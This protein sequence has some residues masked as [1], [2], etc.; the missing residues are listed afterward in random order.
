MKRR[1]QPLALF[2]VVVILLSGFAVLSPTRGARA[3]TRSP[4]ID[5]PKQTRSPRPDA[6]EQDASAQPQAQ[7]QGLSD[8][9]R[10]QIESL[11]REKESRNKAQAK[12]DSQLIYA[13]KQQRGEAITDAVETLEVDV[14]VDERGYTLV[15]IRA[16]VTAQVLSTIRQVGGKVIS[17]FPRDEAIRASLP[18]SSI[19]TVAGLAEV[20]FIRPAEV[21]YTEKVDA[22]GKRAVSDVVVNP[23]GAPRATAPPAEGAVNPTLLRG[24]RPGFAERAANT[25]AR[26]EA[27]LAARV[28]PVREDESQPDIGAA[29]AES[30]TTERTREARN[31]YGLN[32]KGIKIGI[33][34]D[35]FNFRNEYSKD[36]ATGDLPGP[37]NPYGYTTPVTVVQESSSTDEGRAM[38]QIIHD[39]VP[40]AQLFFATAN[41]GQANFA[42]NIRILRNTH[43]CDII[44]DD[45]GYFLES[46]LHKS[47]IVSRAVDD[48]VAAGAMYF[49]SAGNAGNFNDG[50]SGIW[51]GDFRDAGVGNTGGITAVVAGGTWH[52][53]DPGAAVATQNPVNRTTTENRAANLFWS[54]PLGGSCNDYDLYLISGTLDSGGAGQV[55]AASTTLQTCT[56]DPAEQVTVPGSASGAP[57]GRRLAIFKKATA[58]TRFLHLTTNRS[59]FDPVN[60]AAIPA[61]ETAGQANGHDATGD[62]YATAATPAQSPGPFPGV[63]TGAN[64]VETFSSDGPRRIFYKYDNTP[65][66]A[67]LTSTGGVVLQKPEITAA[68]RVSTTVPG[69]QPFSGTSAAA[70]TAAAIAALIKASSTSLTPTQ[71]LNSMT[72][73]AIDIEAPGVDRDS[74]VGIVMAYQALQSLS[75]P[76]GATVEAG[77][78][79]VTPANDCDSA[80]NPGEQGSITV[81]LNNVGGAT[82]TAVSATLTSSTAG[83][84]IT[85]GASAY[86]DIPNGG[87]ASNSTPFTFQLSN[88]LSC[89]Q[90]I[91]FSLRV[92][93]TGG[94]AS[95]INFPFTVQLAGTP[96][97][98][99]STFAYSGAPVTIP[100]NNS[101]GVN[102]P[103]TVSGFTGAVSDLN[104]KFGGTSCNATEGSTTNGVNHPFVGDV[105]F[106]LTSPSGKTVTIISQ[107]GGA[108]NSGNNFC[109]TV[110][111]DDTANG[112][113]QSVT[114]AQNPYTGTFKPANPLSAFDGENPNGTWLLNASDVG[115]TDV[116]NV[117]AFSLDITAFS[118]PASPTSTISG[119]IT[120]ANG[121]GID[122]VTVNLSG[123]ETQTTATNS[124]GDYSFSLTTCGLSYT[125]TPSKLGWAFTP[126]S[127][128][129]YGQTN[130]TNVNF[131]GTNAVTSPGQL[132]I[133]EFRL[134]G[135][136]GASD[137][138]IELYN[139]T[140]ANLVVNAADGSGGYALVASD[141]TTRHTIPSGTSIPARGHYLVTNSAGYSLSGYAA[142]DASFTVD[143]PDN[144]GVALFKTADGGGFTEAN[145]LDAAG[146]TS[147]PAL[148]REGAGLAP[149]DPTLNINHAFV[150]DLCGKDG[151]VTTFGPCPSGGLPTDSDD[152]AA[153]FFF[154]DTQGTQTGTVRR[155]GAPG[156]ESMASPVQRNSSF[157]GLSLDST[158]ASSSSPNRE[159]TIAQDTPNNSTFG[160]LSIRRRIVNNTGANV[161]RLRFRVID[162]STYEAPTGTADLRARTSS[163]VTVSDINDTA[164]CAAYGLTPPC[165]VTVQGTTLETPPTQTSGGGFNST[166]SV[167]VPGGSLANGASISV[168]FLLGIMQTGRFKFYVNI[169]ALTDVPPPPAAASAAQPSNKLR[170]LITES[171]SPTT[172]TL[173]APLQ[174]QPR[175]A[176]QAVP[177]RQ[178]QP[179]QQAPGRWLYLPHIIRTAPVEKSEPAAPEA[180][181]EP[182]APAAEPEPEQRPVSKKKKKRASSAK[183]AKDESGQDSPEEEGGKEGRDASEDS[184]ADPPA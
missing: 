66:T 27:A 22:D 31:F 92:T 41:G 36:I 67:D 95:P 111:D 48:V 127:R 7:E 112:S 181:P 123:S 160:T 69:F 164:T 38:A 29:T 65:Y 21:P 12:I 108:S 78:V 88:S 79:T 43:N 107:A 60:G 4:K 24:L 136:G 182:A 2:L 72:S 59:R 178:N 44:V 118:C 121:N 168:Q 133:T 106:K 61:W 49:A 134:R 115:A 125:V 56:Q 120:D 171:Q 90:T 139:N 34:S 14:K 151:S 9:T 94:Q 47:A 114:A 30:D 74:G 58:A 71:V 158:K 117:T 70:P 91:N 15:D 93:F 128:T 82:A 89:G 55:V 51:E 132:I 163:N 57:G 166:L 83:V 37:G 142:G 126:P 170:R 183:K 54:D 157:P 64:Q 18:L 148:Y 159:R 154:V 176:Q 84:T 40:G 5:A 138:F 156:P 145:R 105:I 13:A 149:I 62:G 146:F 162:I 42:N 103:V 33:L 75:T 122:A 68:D 6:P 3:Q 17:S 25:R 129:F 131:V 1:S 76:P 124:N 109:N 174:S 173:E 77:A 32:G 172:G 110:L 63:H 104:F 10:A 141:G 113:I 96:G 153:D 86:P 87:S 137:E 167:A 175:P 39:I 169:E 8:V 35:S 80:L 152:N 179:A 46:P 28:A 81:A 11:V 143:I 100:D 116:G 180:K 23:A 119:R 144:G 101:A 165:E 73:T 184:P 99:P 130:N 85:Q 19:E 50:T 135:T 16:E 45:V 147:A 53:F 52:D 26:L 161:T 97:A 140:D 150:R 20:K 155:L 102:I 98:T 177:T